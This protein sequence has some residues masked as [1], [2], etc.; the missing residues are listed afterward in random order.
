M[1]GSIIQ[2]LSLAIHGN[3]FLRGYTGTPFFPGNST[4]QFCKDISFILLQPGMGQPSEV[5]FANAPDEWFANQARRGARR[6]RVWWASGGD[7][8]MPDR[9]LV[10]FVGGGGHWRID[11][12]LAD[13][14]ESWEGYWRVGDQKDPERRIWNVTYVR[15]SWRPTA[16]FV[17]KLTLGAHVEKLEKLLPE[18]SAFARRQSLTSFAEFFERGLDCLHAPNPL[19]K[20][21]HK[22]VAPQGFLP[23]DAERLLAATQAAWVFGAMGSWNDL[24]FTSFKSLEREEYEQLSERLYHALNEAAIDAA[25]SLPG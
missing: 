10:G 12:L 11:T 19:A 14:S 18:A 1:Q 5:P 17:Q 4:C 21:F 24:G 13:A 20:V 16:P 23:V 22:D 8:K 6:H 3:A 9:M 15:G 7:P 25:N 2:T